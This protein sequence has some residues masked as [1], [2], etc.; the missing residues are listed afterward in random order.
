[1][2]KQ[3]MLVLEL[4][5]SIDTCLIYCIF[6]RQDLIFLNFHLSSRSRIQY[7]NRNF[8]FYVFTPGVKKGNKQSREG[9]QM[10]MADEMCVKFMTSFLNLD[11]DGSLSK[12]TNQPFL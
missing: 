5:L 10:E 9:S 4:L 7:L 12:T 2:L 1:M 6:F 3:K 8:V 11:F